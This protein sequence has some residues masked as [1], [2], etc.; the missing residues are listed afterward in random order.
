M[1]L[2]ECIKYIN[3]SSDKPENSE[4]IK[5][6][7]KGQHPDITLITCSDSRLK[8]EQEMDLGKIFTIREMGSILNNSSIASIEYSTLINVKKI[9][10]VSHTNCGAIKAAFELLDTNSNTE[11]EEILKSKFLT[12]FIEA[13]IINPLNLHS[14]T[15]ANLNETII[16]NEEMQIEKLLNKSPMIKNKLKENKLEIATAQYS[17]ETG[18]IKL[19]KNCIY[20]NEKTK[21]ITNTEYNLLLKE[22]NQIKENKV[23]TKTM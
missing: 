20:K 8:L 10:F 13:D 9:L 5:E 19:L 14:N 22:N 21:F 18:K 4:K 11:K 12:K 23:K 2:E 6:L 1:D 17:T 3:K 16:K 7:S 15:D